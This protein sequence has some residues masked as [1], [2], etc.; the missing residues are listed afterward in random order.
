M[1]KF[2]SAHAQNLLHYTYPMQLRGIM[3]AE[4]ELFKPI[5]KHDLTYWRARLEL[6]ARIRAPYAHNREEV[7]PEADVRLAE[8]HCREI[9]NVI[10]EWSARVYF[11]AFL[12]PS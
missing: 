6:L 9:L 1:R 10:R 11:L 5:M 3:Q 8:I 4:W 12:N 2:P 7:V